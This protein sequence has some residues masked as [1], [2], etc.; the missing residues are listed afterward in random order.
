MNRLNTRY[1]T[2]DTSNF[3]RLFLIPGMNHCSGGPATDAFDGFGALVN[4]VENG[5]APDRI[6]GTARAGNADVTWPNRTRPLCPYPKQARYNGT[7][8]I[9]DAASFTCQAPGT[10]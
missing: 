5:Q 1:G 7:G 4:W 9:E 10:R 3:S 6:I 2:N 8:S